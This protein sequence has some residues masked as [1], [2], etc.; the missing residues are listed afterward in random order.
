MISRPE[1][2]S[3]IQ[4]CKVTSHLW[5]FATIFPE[6]HS[7]L[8]DYLHIILLCI[9]KWEYHTHVMNKHNTKKE[10]GIARDSKGKKQR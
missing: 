4:S 3:D 1:W 7:S 5:G 6:V 2:H 9:I 10:Q 8:Q